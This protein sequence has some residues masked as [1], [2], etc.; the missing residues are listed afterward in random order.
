MDHLWAKS[1]KGKGIYIMA[2][3]NDQGF[4]VGQQ[5]ARAVA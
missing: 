5:L 1:S 2:V 4:T 3:R